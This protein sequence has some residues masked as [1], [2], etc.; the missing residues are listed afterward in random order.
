MRGVEDDDTPRKIPVRCQQCRR[1]LISAA[2]VR[3]EVMILGPGNLTREG[4][5]GLRV[6]STINDAPVRHRAAVCYDASPP[7]HVFGD[8]VRYPITRYR[9]VCEHRGGSRLITLKAHTL[10]AMC[11]EALARGVAADVLV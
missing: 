7:P 2:I 4:A 3:G 8:L 11:G 9:F 10:K 1:V 6:T 5:P